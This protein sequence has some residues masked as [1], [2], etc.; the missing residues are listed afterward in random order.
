MIRNL[1]FI[2]IEIEGGK[3]DVPTWASA[4]PVFLKWGFKA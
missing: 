3:H 4:M 2:I 1:I